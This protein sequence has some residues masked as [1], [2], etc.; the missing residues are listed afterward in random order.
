[1]CYLWN[2]LVYFADNVNILFQRAESIPKKEIADM[3]KSCK[4]LVACIHTLDRELRRTM[5]LYHLFPLIPD[6]GMYIPY[7][8]CLNK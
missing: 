5:Y 3:E 1:M 7:L 4:V 2:I 8:Y 6:I